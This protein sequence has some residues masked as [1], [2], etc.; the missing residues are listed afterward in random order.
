MGKERGGA[1]AS[2]TTGCC[3][4]MMFQS[5]LP[6]RGSD[7]WCTPGALLFPSF[8]PRS[9]RGGATSRRSRPSSGRTGFNPRSRGGATRPRQVRSGLRVNPRSHE[10]ATG[11]RALGFKQ[12]LIHAPH[13]RAISP[14]LLGNRPVSIHAP[15]SD[16]QTPSSATSM[17]FNHAPTGSGETMTVVS[18]VLP[19]HAPTRND[20]RRRKCLDRCFQS[21]LPEERRSSISCL[22]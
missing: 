9:P 17:S 20:S 15:T 14:P 3:P 2:A 5:T 12:L 16:R 18:L 1:T 6:T 22:R 10:G 21:T 13:E 11:R 7:L 4:V 8:N 19:I